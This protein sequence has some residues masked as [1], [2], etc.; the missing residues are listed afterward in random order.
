MNT[1]PARAPVL[2]GLRVLDRTSGIAGPYCTKLLA[3]AGA[4]VVKVEAGAGDPLRGQGTGALFEFLNA[5]KRSVTDDASL[6]A[7]ADVVVCDEP[8]TDEERRHARPAVVA[9]SI[10]PFGRCGPW[11]ATRPWTEFTLQAACGSI[12]QRPASD[13]AGAGRNPG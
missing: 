6:L 5:S 3:D 4:D 2:D 8:L 11:A 7:A 1:P 13:G 10:T 9:V 12:G